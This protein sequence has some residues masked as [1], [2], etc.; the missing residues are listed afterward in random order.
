MGGGALSPNCRTTHGWENPLAQ[1]CAKCA[2]HTTSTTGGESLPPA[3]RFP[4]AGGKA[5]SPAKGHSNGCG[6]Q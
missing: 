6:V 3:Q 4:T 2:G 5:L 1:P